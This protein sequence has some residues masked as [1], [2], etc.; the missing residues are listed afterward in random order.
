MALHPLF[1]HSLIFATTVLA[2][3]ACLVTTVATVQL[4]LSVAFFHHQFPATVKPPCMFPRFANR[5]FLT[6][7][8]RSNGDTVYGKEI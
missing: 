5:T 6:R 1:C 2:S 7:S 8:H 4:S 3:V